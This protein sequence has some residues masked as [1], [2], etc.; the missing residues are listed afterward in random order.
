VRFCF[1]FLALDAPEIKLDETGGGGK[2]DGDTGYN[3]RQFD[4]QG[5]PVQV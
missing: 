2:G 1:L 3:R 5:L 4:D